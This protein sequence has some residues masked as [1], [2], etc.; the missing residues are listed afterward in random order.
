[1]ASEEALGASP[2]YRYKQGKVQNKRKTR[3]VC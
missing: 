1:M 3:A 2:D